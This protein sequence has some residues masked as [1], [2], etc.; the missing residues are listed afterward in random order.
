MPSCRAVVVGIVE[1]D[2][3]SH[4]N[5]SLK[6]NTLAAL[7]AAIGLSTMFTDAQAASPERANSRDAHAP[8]KIRIGVMDEIPL[9]DDPVPARAALSVDARAREVGAPA[10][11]RAS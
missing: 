9:P 10:H 4:G 11:R 1:G 2:F 8:R 7:A 3:P 5:A 6:R